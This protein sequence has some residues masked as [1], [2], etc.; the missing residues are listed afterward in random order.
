LPFLLPA[1]LRFAAAM[2]SLSPAA[3]GAEVE[4]MAQH[5]TLMA[6]SLIYQ[7]V[8]VVLILTGLPL[9]WTPIPVGLILIAAGLALIVSNSNRARDGV[10]ALR[11]KHDRLDRWLCKAERIV[12]HPFN[13][14]LQQTETDTVTDGWERL[15]D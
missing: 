14:I 7:F 5:L 6:M 1:N 9:F 2:S 10:R 12:P 11:R 13:R 15:R 4:Y 8:G 3:N